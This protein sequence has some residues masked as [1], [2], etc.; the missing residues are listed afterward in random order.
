MKKS[1]S[2][3][4]FSILVSLNLSAQNDVQYKTS[5]IIFT[6][7][8]VVDADKITKDYFPVL[9]SM[10]MPK[11]G[12]EE[13][14]AFLEGIKKNI[15][16]N[17]NPVNR[18]FN[19]TVLPPPLHLKGFEG[20]KFFTGIP[21]DNDVAI[22]NNGF[23]VSVVNQT[24]NVFDTNGTLL[25]AWSFNAFADTLKL[26]ANK[27]DGRVLYDPLKDRFVVALLCGYDSSTSKCILGFSQTNNPTGK[28]NIYAVQGAPLKDKTWSDY[29]ILA[30]TKDELFLT[31]NAVNNG[32]VDWKTAFHQS[33][34]WQIDKNTGYDGKPLATKVYSDIIF[35]GKNIRNI[36]PV[37][38]GSTL[39]GPDVYFL[40]NKNF[41]PSTDTF[42]LLHLSGL[43]TDTAT[44]LSIQL[45]RSDKHYGVSPN[46]RQK[47]PWFLQTND[48]RVLD[49]FIENGKIQMVGNSKN[50][51]NYASAF[52]GVISDIKTNP[53]VRLNIL[54]DSNI[55]LGFPAIAYV[56][57]DAQSDDAIILVNH[58]SKN[59][60]PGYSSFLYS[61]NAYSYLD[62][63][64]RGTSKINASVNPERWGD[65]SGIQRKYNQP[66]RVWMAATFGYFKKV[67]QFTSFGTHGTWISEVGVPKGFVGIE[68]KTA[69]VTESKLYPNPVMAYEPLSIEFYLNKE[70]IINISLHDISG[71][72][73][74][75][76]MKTKGEEGKNQ[77]IFNTKA[78]KPGNYILVVQNENGKRK[79]SKRFVVL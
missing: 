14:N 53:I 60:F 18:S 68:P 41:S 37:Q 43:M 12:G 47:K 49:A 67:D 27:Y 46:A 48:A 10:E 62:T 5:E 13:Y 52:H 35:K 65:Y 32:S 3:S 51:F 72:F 73:I 33:Y 15:K 74:D 28:W 59:V 22:S 4:L 45:L 9:Q 57:K 61:A 21:N 54:S 25:K 75:L 6:A 26:K 71:K 29:P 55:D 19:K 50:E 17:L 16:P 63:L 24:I 39:Y 78:L 23:I 79:F 34:I 56:G 7:P 76:L 38:G 70:E 8:M 30:L 2:L 69:E 66:D 40:S 11:P 77:F 64:K 31:L 58:T 42:F 20:N 1:I 44:K 36:C